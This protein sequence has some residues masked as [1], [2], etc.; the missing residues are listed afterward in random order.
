MRRQLNNALLGQMKFLRASSCQVPT[1]FLWLL[2]P[3]AQ[4]SPVSLTLAFP[5]NASPRSSTPAFSVQ[6]QAPTD[7][8][9]SIASLRSIVQPGRLSNGLTI[10]QMHSL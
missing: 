6:P 1:G 2:S 8:S 10:L 3:K 7:M 5:T 9:R 4:H